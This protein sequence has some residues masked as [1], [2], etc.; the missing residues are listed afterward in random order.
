M[1]R[2]RKDAELRSPAADPRLTF[3]ESILARGNDPH[4]LAQSMHQR[5]SD[6]AERF[7]DLLAFGTLSAQANDDRMVADFDQLQFA[8][9][10]LNHGARGVENSLDGWPVFGDDRG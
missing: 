9:I 10:G 1:R 5:T 4:C 8:A 7:A 6:T 3:S 2:T